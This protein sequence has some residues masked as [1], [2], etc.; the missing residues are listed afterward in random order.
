M[1]SSAYEIRFAR[2]MEA[3]RRFAAREGHCDV[4]Y[5]H[6][7]D[8]DGDEVALGRWTT[9]VRMRKRAGKIPA[10]RIAQL[11]TVPGWTWEPRRPGP[12]PQSE[13]NRLMRKLRAEGVS[14]SVLAERFGLSKQRVYQLTAGVKPADRNEP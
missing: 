7:E 6:V 14:L 3:L 9:Y 10:S 2:H 4:P 12:A 1:A 5:A 11:S 13:R 8:V